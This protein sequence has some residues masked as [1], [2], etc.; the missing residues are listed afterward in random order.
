M[1]LDDHNAPHSYEGVKSAFI[2]LFNSHSYI[3]SLLFIM[4]WIMPHDTDTKKLHSFSCYKHFSQ[5]T[6]GF[7][8]NCIQLRKAFGS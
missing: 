5:L 2:S 1:K 3:V 8:F 7:V 4:R 6:Y